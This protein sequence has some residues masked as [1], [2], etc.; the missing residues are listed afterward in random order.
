MAF[1]SLKSQ[2]DHPKGI[3]SLLMIVRGD[4]I[5]K[6]VAQLV[7]G[8]FGITPVAFSFGWVSY[9]VTALFS[10]I[11]DGRLM[12]DV[13]FSSIV[14]NAST[15]DERVNKSWVLSRLLRDWEKRASYDYEEPALVVTVFRLLGETGRRG[16]HANGGRDLE[17]NKESQIHARRLRP[18]VPM[19]DLQWYTGLLV[20]AFQLIIASFA[21][22]VHKQWL[23]MIV[24]FGG[25]VLCLAGGALPQLKKEKWSCRKLEAN[26]PDG[27]SPTQKTIVL[28]QGNGHRHVM[29]IHS[30]GKGLNLEDLATA[31][32]TN[33]RSTLPCLLILTIFWLL[34]L[35]TVG[36]F[37]ENTWCLIA[38]TALGTAQNMFAAGHHRAPSTAGIHLGKPD[39]IIPDPSRQNERGKEIS[40]KVFQVLKKT[41]ERMC[42][43]YGI[44]GVGILLL[45]VFFKKLRENEIEWRDQQEAKYKQQN[46]PQ[47]PPVEPCLSYAQTL[48]RQHTDKHAQGGAIAEEILPE[49]RPKRLE[50]SS[51]ESVE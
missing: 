5:Q 24:T 15:G 34:L 38:V 22:I 19:L 47:Q 9:T 41:E 36:G 26:A 28:T 20:M 29:I 43:E 1:D 7:G 49:H 17:E 32:L 39:Y 46:D 21:G 45:P 50:Q 11:A 4:V 14:I 25:T 30:D 33:H 42:K 44:N 31:R 27:G 35:F 6:A 10:T 40:N 2:I 13:E 8:P 37:S 16:Q 48:V 23:T 18:G 12:P 51:G 3:F